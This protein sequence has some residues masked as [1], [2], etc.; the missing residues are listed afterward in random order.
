MKDYSQ[1]RRVLEEENITS[2]DVL[3]VAAVS[4]SLCSS[5]SDREFNALCKC[6]DSFIEDCGHIQLIADVV[7]DLYQDCGF[8]YLKDYGKAKCSLEKLETFDGNI[9][10]E[11]WSII[12]RNCPEPM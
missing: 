11:I 10:Q 2:L 4:C 1:I 5:V 9:K 8:G 6:V 12:Q 7:V 3:A